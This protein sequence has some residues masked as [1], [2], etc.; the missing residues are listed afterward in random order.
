MTITFKSDRGDHRIN[1]EE[2]SRRKSNVQE[3]TTEIE[4]EWVVTS[5]GWEAVA[6]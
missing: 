5:V 2:T 3:I 1:I 4:E 6:T